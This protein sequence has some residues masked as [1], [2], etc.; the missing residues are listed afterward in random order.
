MLLFE[1]VGANAASMRVGHDWSRS[2]R[3]V[4]VG[5]GRVAVGLVVVVAVGSRGRGRGQYV[6]RFRGTSCSDG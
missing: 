3:G 6:H 2:G 4:A 5:R 1:T